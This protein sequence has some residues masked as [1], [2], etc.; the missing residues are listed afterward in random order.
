MGLFGH[1]T[2]LALAGPREPVDCGA[3]PWLRLNKTLGLPAAL[4]TQEPRDLQRLR[5]RQHPAKSGTV[6]RVLLNPGPDGH[7]GI[8]LLVWPRTDLR[9]VA[10]DT[11]VWGLCMCV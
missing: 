4:C 9:V 6:F 1:I 7:E 3:A 2:A 5:P 11:G 8:R 10:R